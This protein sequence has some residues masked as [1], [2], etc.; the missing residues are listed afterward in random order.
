MRSIP[1]EPD[2]RSPRAR[3]RCRSLYLSAS[4]RKNSRVIALKRASRTGPL[5]ERRPLP[6][7]KVYRQLR[8]AI[9]E[10]ADQIDWTN[11]PD[12][13]PEDSGSQEPPR[14]RN[15]DSNRESLSQRTRPQA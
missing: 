5:T 6:P 14:W 8:L 10:M 12:V 7:K 1:S 4:I 2:M 9:P 15:Q 3:Y 11:C 13:D